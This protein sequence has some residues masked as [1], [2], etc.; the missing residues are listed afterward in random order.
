M[1]QLNLY[2]TG[3]ISSAFIPFITPNAQ[4]MNYVGPGRHV[5]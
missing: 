1:A 3:A 4:G 2:P 5:G